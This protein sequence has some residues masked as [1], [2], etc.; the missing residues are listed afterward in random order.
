[1]IHMWDIWWDVMWQG[2][3]MMYDDITIWASDHMSMGMWLWSVMTICEH[4]FQWW[5]VMGQ[6]GVHGISSN[7]HSV[8]VP[9]SWKEHWKCK[10]HIWRWVKSKSIIWT[11][12]SDCT[13]TPATNCCSS[14]RGG[15]LSPKWWWTHLLSPCHSPSAIAIGHPPV[16][17]RAIPYQLV[18]SYPVDD[19]L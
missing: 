14:N 10:G 11:K 9:C 5:V 8:N 6:C 15:E 4:V 7:R 1:M 13:A 3:V 17:N 18:D 16:W 19:R 12:I 2:N